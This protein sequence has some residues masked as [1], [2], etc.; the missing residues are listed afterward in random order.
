MTSERFP[1]LSIA[2]CL[3]NNDRLCIFCLHGQQ[4]DQYDIAQLKAGENMGMCQ[5]MQHILR[6]QNHG[7]ALLQAC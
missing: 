6:E 4:A 5:N 1:P 3:M 7:V 2:P